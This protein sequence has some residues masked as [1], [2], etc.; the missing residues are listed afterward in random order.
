MAVEIV[1]Q[2][3]KYQNMSSYTPLIYIDIDINIYMQFMICQLHLS[4]DT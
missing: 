3:Y 1:E 4:K 2:K